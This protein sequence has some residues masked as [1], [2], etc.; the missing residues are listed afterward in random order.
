MD[1][2]RFLALSSS[3]PLAAARLDARVPEAAVA[4]Q[5]ADARFEDIATLV[6]EQM[7]AYRVPGVGL[8]VVADGVT[9]LRGFGVTSLDDPRPVTEDT[10]FTIASISKTITATAEITAPTTR[11]SRR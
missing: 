6:R 8:G 4:A 3:L 11:R 1:R 10:L 7:R 5:A 9:T 2:R